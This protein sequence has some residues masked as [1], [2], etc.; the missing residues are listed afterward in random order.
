MVLVDDR[1]HL[2]LLL[3]LHYRVVNLGDCLFLPDEGIQMNRHLSA[4]EV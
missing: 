4:K 1:E 2:V 3:R